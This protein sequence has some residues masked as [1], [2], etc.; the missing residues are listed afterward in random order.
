MAILI[1]FLLRRLARALWWEQSPTYQRPSSSGERAEELSAPIE[2]LDDPVSHLF[3]SPA[4]HAAII[5]TLDNLPAQPR[6]VF[7]MSRVDRLSYS[8]IALRLG[9]SR[10][11]VHR[12]MK[13]VIAAVARAVPV[14]ESEDR[15][16]T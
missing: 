7:L 11:A 3:P 5:E 15:D 8:E 14:D 13:L 10:R 1:P 16:R 4:V 12:A 6:L 9:V 2:A